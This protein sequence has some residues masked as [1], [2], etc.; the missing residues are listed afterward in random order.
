MF[1]RTV[2]AFISCLW[3]AFCIASPQHDTQP[4]PSDLFNS[5][6]ELS[7]LVDIAYCVGTT[8]VQ[9]PFQCLSHCAEF[10]DLELLT[11]S[12]LESS[13]IANPGSRNPYYS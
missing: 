4:V 12:H 10:P 2:L 13:Q 11:V 7:R 9:E 1:C 6:E 8:G 3:L 5:L